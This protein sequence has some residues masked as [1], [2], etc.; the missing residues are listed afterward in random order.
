MVLPAG[1]L[2][3]PLRVADF[4]ALTLML[5]PLLPGNWS[6]ESLQG[7]LI[8]SHHCRVLCH[9]DESGAGLLGFAEFTAVADECELLNLA[10]AGEQQGCGLGR[11]L[12]HAVLAESRDKGCARCFLEVRRSNEAAIALYASEGFVLAGVRKSYYP[13]RQPQAQSED[14][15]LYS[16]TL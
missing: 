15:L 5:L 1:V 10:V 9:T 8:S 3:R 7:L 6:L 11:A 14:A 13:P 16:L 2:Y 4:P 12:L